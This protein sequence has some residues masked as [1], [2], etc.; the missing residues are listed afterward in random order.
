M[1]R[2]HALAAALLVATQTDPP[3][4]SNRTAACGISLVAPVGWSAS[5]SIVTPG[6]CWFGLRPVDWQRVR[7]ESQFT[8]SEEAVRITVEPGTLEDLFA[9]GEAWRD[10]DGES[11]EPNGSP[12]TLPDG[13]HAAVAAGATAG[14]TSRRPHPG[15][16]LGLLPVEAHS[17]EAGYLN[18]Q[19]TAWS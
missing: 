8:A 10:Q 17:K 14:A 11:V 1:F 5:P 4:S 12:H 7:A 3:H 13:R 19:W 16:G 2:I 15:R 6:S 18:E 9:K